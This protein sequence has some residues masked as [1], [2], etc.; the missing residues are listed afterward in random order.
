MTKVSVIIPSY[1]T[2]KHPQT[3]IEALL[4]QTIKTDYEVIV[5]DDKSSQEMSH[6]LAEFASEPKIRVFSLSEQAGAFALRNIGCKAA[7]GE[8][9]AFIEPDCLPA[10][11]W[12]R[13]L[14]SPI[15]QQ[16]AA[17]VQGIIRSTGRGLWVELEKARISLYRGV[18]TKNFAIKKEILEKIGGFDERFRWSD[19]VSA[20]DVDFYERLGKAGFTLFYEDKAVVYHYW[21]NNPLEFLG[22]SRN[23]SLGR[24]IFL[25]K[26]NPQSVMYVAK[27]SLARYLAG[28]FLSGLFESFNKTRKR[29]KLPFSSKMIFFFYYLF[30]YM[31]TNYFMWNFCKHHKLMHRQKFPRKQ[32]L[33]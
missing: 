22:K 30:F 13:S 28:R 4:N 29:V 5:I 14:I 27:K 1:R 3:C 10:R 12:L 16:K 9:I 26:H 21:P 25:L 7:N 15:L 2:S 6:I 17:A 20:G 32:H 18:K 24:I 23:Y 19:D 8:I 11:N 31:C 33:L